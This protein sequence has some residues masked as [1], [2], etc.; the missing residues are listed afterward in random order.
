MKNLVQFSV[1]K[2]I[3][4]F[5]AVLI[6]IIFGVVS[7]TNLTTD[8]FPNMNIPYSVVLTTYGGASPDEVEEVVTTPLEE[9]LATTTNIKEITSISQENISIIMLEFN[10]DTNMDSAVIEMRENLDMLTSAFPDM[11]GDPMIIKLNPDLMPIMQISVTK[12]GFTQQELTNYVDED[13][14]PQIERVPGVASVSVSGAYE[15][16]IQVVLDEA[17]I[18]TVNAQITT[19]FESIPG[20]DP[21]DAMLL[22]K[23]LISNLLMAQNFEYPVGYANL[24]DGLNYLVRVGDEFGDLDDIRE[25]LIFNFPGFGDIPAIQLSVDDIADVTYVN[26]NDKEYSKVNGENAITFSIQKSSDFATTDVTDEINAII[27]ALDDDDT[28]LE[29]TVLLDQGD[30]INNA[31]GTVATNLLYGAIL[32]VIV[33]FV[34]LRSARATSIVAVSIPISLMFALVLIYFTGITLNIVSLGGLALGIG[35]LVD[36]SIVVIENIFRFKHEGYSNRDAAIEGTKQ[37]AGA[38]TASTITTISVFIPVLFIEGFIKEIFMQM[39]LTIAYSLTAS[40]LIALTLVPAISSKVLKEDTKEKNESSLDKSKNIYGRILELAFRFKYIVLAAVVLLFGGSIVLALTNGFEYFPS[41]D[42]GQLT[43]T[44]NNPVDDPLAYNDFVTTLD[45]IADDI[46]AYEDVEVVGLSLGSMQG[47][48]FGITSSDTATANV[49]LIDNR[50]NSTLEMQSMLE[51]MLSTEYETIDFEIAGSQQQ[52]DMLT[53]SGFQ[54]EIRGYDLDVLKA[55]AQELAD[56]VATVEGVEAVDNGVGIPAEEVKITVN[57]D[58]AMSYGLTTAQ[59]LGAVAELLAEEEVTTTVNVTGDLYDLYVYDSSSNYSGTE[60]SLTELQN[61][62]IGVNF[63]NPLDVITVGDVATVEII[64]GFQS[65]S[66]TNG[67]RTIT[68][69][70][71]FDE[72]YNGTFVA[73]DIEEAIADYTLPDDFE[74]EVAGENEEIMEALNTLVLAIALGVVLIY[75]VMASQ[76]QSLTYPFIIMA[77]LPLAFTGGFL[78]LFLSGMPVSVVATIGFVILVGVVVNNGIVLVDY[79]NQL[80]EQGLDIKEALLKAGK[81]RLRPIIMTALTTI[82]ALSTMAIGIGEGAEMMQPMAVTTIGG[83]LYATVLTLVVV[84]IMYYLVTLHERGIFT[85]FGLIVF[86]LATPLTYYFYSEWYV[87]VIGIVA[88]VAVV[89]SWVFRKKSGAVNV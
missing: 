84:P 51:T 52:T 82:L 64:D 23:E 40:L 14:L 71:T 68:V 16:E 70:A 60:Y 36:N 22:D 9:T 19:L 43:I 65:I 76:F 66:H 80:R 25:M 47:S 45:N 37:V 42:E 17:A 78:I 88:F 46:L 13:I 75:M 12:E 86:G 39:A 73:Q 79:T 67:T 44:I 7:Y 83:M 58:V 11:V 59:V 81:T 54:L 48:M 62:P 26:A 77:T 35:M 33:L 18:D 1:N 21:E 53:G 6:V 85:S 49:V 63:M 29:F 69:S 27:R 87:L 38:I 3:T 30:Y 2:A 24:D 41:S 32:A 89:L 50:E 55:T 8:L 20:A 56:I 34:F 15:S 72:N 31:T 10:G 5:M 57:K 61:L 4:V 28:T 74:M